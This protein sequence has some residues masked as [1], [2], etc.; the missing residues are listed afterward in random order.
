MAIEKLQNGIKE[1]KW[2]EN[3]DRKSEEDQIEEACLEQR[4][5]EK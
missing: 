2:R 5:D 4:Y 3:E 1:L